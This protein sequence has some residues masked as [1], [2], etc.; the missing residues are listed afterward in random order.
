MTKRKSAAD[1]IGAIGTSPSDIKRPERMP[2]QERRTLKGMFGRATKIV[3][4]DEMNA[5]IARCGSLAANRPP[6]GGTVS[7]LHVRKTSDARAGSKPN[8]QPEWVSW[9]RLLEGRRA[10]LLAVWEC[11]GIKRPAQ[12]VARADGFQ[13]S[14]S[15][16]MAD[17]IV[18]QGISSRVIGPLGD[19]LGLGKGAL[20]DLLDLNRS[21]ARRRAA[22]DQPLPAPA[23]KA[24]LRLLDLA[25]LAAEVFDAEADM[26]R[27]LR[28]RHPMLD[29]K[30]ALEAAKT[31]DGSQRVKG[32]LH[33]IKYGGV[34]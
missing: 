29:G 17:Q 16:A 2:I 20:A 7:G 21:T 12:L 33:A 27:W 6:A 24:V 13:F 31:E 32:I 14:I 3:S 11:F 25:Q 23:A 22:L 26:F 30:T 15:D 28:L 5:T 4:I 34:I 8:T 19:F 10:A 1:L 9:S 18:E